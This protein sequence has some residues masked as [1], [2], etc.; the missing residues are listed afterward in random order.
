MWGD[1]KVENI[2]DS[3]HFDYLGALMV[4]GVEKYRFNA[5]DI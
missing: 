3:Y 5:T 1:L 4:A 2:A